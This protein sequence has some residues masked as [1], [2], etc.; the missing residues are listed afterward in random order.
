M[1]VDQAAD[2]RGALAPLIDPHRPET[3][4]PLTPVKQLRHLPQPFFWDVAKAGDL[5]GRPTGRDIKKSVVVLGVV[6]DERRVLTVLPQHQMGKTVEQRQISAR[7]DGQM[8]VSGLGCV[9]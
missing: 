1:K 5:S 8:N 2:H 4:D 3:E 7:G 6:V 9:R